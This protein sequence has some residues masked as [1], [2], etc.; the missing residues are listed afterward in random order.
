MNA[1]SSS[2]TIPTPSAA[3]AP[4]AAETWRIRVRMDDRPGTLARLAI[5]LADLGCNILGLTVIPVPDGVVDEL[6]IRPPGGLTSG[7]LVA[8]IRVEGWECSNVADADI[9]N[10]A[11]STS[12]TLSSAA[13]AIDDPEAWPDVLRDLLAADTVTVVD[14]AQAEPQ[15]TDDGHRVVV[16]FGQRAAVVRR[17]WAAITDIELS[18]ARAMVSVLTAA[19]TTMR[20]PKAVTCDD[21]AAIVLR[22][23]VE[24]DVDALAELHAACSLQTLYAR[25]HTGMRSVPRRWLHR[26]LSPPD[27]L[28]LVAVAGSE[29]VGYAQL[30][31]AGA[32]AS[33]TTARS[34]EVSLLVADEWQGKGVGTALLARLCVLA[35]A[36]GLDSLFA[37]CLQGDRRVLGAARRAGVR[38]TPVDDG[39][40]LRVDMDTTMIDGALTVC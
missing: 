11:D 12:T 2:A 35:S 31:G 14:P 19:Q 28:S 16:H 21:G 24:S 38:A 30:I 20:T 40:Q 32:S 7:D 26:L 10:L 4:T 13:R 39:E 15:R 5:R 22:E 9:R 34:A 3:A 36:R 29:V 1:Q 6:V 25:Y 23:G 33:A 27:G 37:M 8:A 18:R 17:R